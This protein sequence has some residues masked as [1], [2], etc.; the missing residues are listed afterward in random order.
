MVV[1]QYT[2]T[3]AQ[4]KA[5]NFPIPDTYSDIISVVYNFNMADVDAHIW[6]KTKFTDDLSAYDC[7]KGGT[8]S[9]H[10]II[11]GAHEETVTVAP[12]QHRLWELVTET[13]T[14]NKAG[15]KEVYC[16]DCSYEAEVSIPKLT[17]FATPSKKTFSL[18]P[19]QKYTGLSVKYA[20]GDSVVSWKSSNSNIV[21]VTKQAGG[22]CLV[23]AGKTQGKAVLT[24]TLKSK[25]T[26]KITVTVRAIK[27]TKITGVKSALTLKVKKTAMLKPVLT[28]RNSTEKITYRSSNAKVAS[29]TSAG[30]ITAKK[31]GTAYIYVKSG[32]KTVK[33]KVV[34]R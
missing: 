12:K 1:I 16:Y 25:K 27:T 31:K 23:V 33:C 5:L 9:Y 8:K 17:P 26:A 3:E 30:K 28:P 32:S 14:I 4:W 11:C 24:V 10:C 21:K 15:L 7:T 29:V 6:T 34:I 22:K 2:G 18:N 19:Q 20:K 13:A